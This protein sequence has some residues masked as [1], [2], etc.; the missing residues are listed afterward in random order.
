MGT[1]LYLPVPRAPEATGAGRRRGEATQAL[2]GSIPAL[3]SSLL[4][5]SGHPDPSGP[6]GRF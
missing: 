1:C 6:G 4:T 2:P 5:A 3:R